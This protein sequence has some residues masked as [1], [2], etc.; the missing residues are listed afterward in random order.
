M[1]P[2]LERRR[3]TADDLHLVQG[4][5]CGDKPW[6]LYLSDWITGKPDGVLEA[7][8][9]GTEVWLQLGEYDV[10]V[11][12]GSLGVT[13]WRY[14]DPF[15][16][17]QATLS[18]IPAFAVQTPFKGEPRN[19]PWDEHYSVRI[20]SDLV[21]IAR[22][23]YAAGRFPDPLLGLFADVR[24]TRAKDF[25]YQFGFI[26]YGKPMKEKERQGK[27]HDTPTYDSQSA[28]T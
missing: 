4:F 18:V 24:N 12:Y 16:G 19:G 8:N 23:W 20:M 11:G 7:L 13:T 5:T 22:Q 3:F 9:K 26:D 17:E 21:S 14:P 28:G 25:Y 10:I 15:G 6:E 2:R 1:E 27:W